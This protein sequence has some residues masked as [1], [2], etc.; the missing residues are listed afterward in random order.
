MDKLCSPVETQLIEYSMSL[1]FEDLTEKGH[2]SS[3]AQSN[4]H[5]WWSTWCF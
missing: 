2:K 5:D 1:G 4:R 3:K